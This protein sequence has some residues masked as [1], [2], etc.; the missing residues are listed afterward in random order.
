MFERPSVFY[1]IRGEPIE[2][3][4]MARQLAAQAEVARRVD[5]APPKMPRPHA[6]DDD[7]RGERVVGRGDGAGQ[8]KAAAA[9]LEGLAFGVGEHL[10]ELPRDGL[11]A[12]M[13]IAALENHRGMRRVDVRQYHRAWRRALA[14]HAPLLDGFDEFF[15]NRLVGPVG[16]EREEAPAEAARNHRRRVLPVKHLPQCLGVGVGEASAF[17]PLRF[18]FGVDGFEQC[19]VAVHNF[20]HRIGWRGGKF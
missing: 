18:P 9:V 19:A 17:V 10:E 14:G 1:E 2:Q 4:G 13:W 5:E 11:A 12:L 8:L 16:N 3:F 6:V 20:L 15:V 7:A